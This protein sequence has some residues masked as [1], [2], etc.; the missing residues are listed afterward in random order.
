MVSA[1]QGTGSPDHGVTTTAA[2]AAPGVGAPHLAM[3][4]R[5]ANSV[6]AI[7]ESMKVGGG[8]DDDTDDDGTDWIW[9]MFMFA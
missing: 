7:A 2:R 9:A 4:M 3:S 5:A 6:K 8:D 1:N